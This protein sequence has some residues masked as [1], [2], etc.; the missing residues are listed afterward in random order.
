MKTVGQKK[1]ILGRRKARGFATSIKI[2]FVTPSI[3]QPVLLSLDLEASINAGF[4]DL[5]GNDWGVVLKGT[6]KNESVL[7]SHASIRSE[8]SIHTECRIILYAKCVFM[9]SRR[10]RSA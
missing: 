6:N 5:I 7:K 10:R 9:K 2:I 1:N 4:K 8:T 3:G